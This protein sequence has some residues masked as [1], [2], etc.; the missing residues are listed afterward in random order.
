MTAPKS[1][2]ATPD[3]DTLLLWMS[4]LLDGELGPEEEQI[5]FAA[6][7]TDP[8]LADELSAFAQGRG[9]VG[10]ALTAL[11]PGD[12]ASLTAAILAATSPGAM[13][14]TADGALRLASLQADDEADAAA[15]A[16][17]DHAL[18]QVP[19]LA[20]DVAAFAAAART[21]GAVMRGVADQAAVQALLAPVAA[22]VAQD[23][24]LAERLDALAL[25]Y[26]DDAASPDEARALHEAFAQ[27]PTHALQAARDV[28]AQAASLAV[29]GA[30]L[31]APATSPFAARAGQA[32]LQA[33]AATVAQDADAARS[34]RSAATQP[35]PSLFARARALLR[36]GLAPLGVAAA[37]MLAFVV[38]S[39]PRGPATVP[40]PTGPATSW[41]Q[42]LLAAA[43]A[44]VDDDT[45]LIGRAAAELP[46]LADND[47]AV[48]ALD[49]GATTAVVFNTEASNITIIWVAEPDEGEMGT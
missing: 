30:A 37:A 8:G 38:A 5:L 16:R 44:I 25:A 27:H 28:V 3:R 18:R 22:R 13:P 34:R 43:G 31:R 10:A 21:T 9:E 41:Q 32:A 45:A 1:P 4:A 48:E 11:D 47:A 40:G 42:D 35:A 20:K 12:A 17:L 14:M 2:P 19:Q 15:A 24:A 23:V 7:A 6:A 29:V 39:D 46:L 26:A 33:I 49:S 36:G